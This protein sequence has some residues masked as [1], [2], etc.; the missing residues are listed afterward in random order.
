MTILLDCD[1]V[2]FDFVGA[3]RIWARTQGHTDERQAWGDVPEPTRKGGEGLFDGPRAQL[4]ARV[5]K[6]SRFPQMVLPYPGAARFVEML[7][8]LLY[9]HEKIIAV[10]APFPSPSWHAVRE[11]A[12]KALGIDSVIFCEAKEKK[13]IVGNWLIE[14]TRSTCLDW[15]F[16]HEDDGG[17]A[18]YLDRGTD[19]QDPAD[20]TACTSL[21][22]HK[23]LIT[24]KW[25]MGGPCSEIYP[26][27][28]GTMHGAAPRGR[29]LEGLR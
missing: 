8:G 24:I 10:T 28:V 5:G 3:V 13:R 29:E 21:T 18:I 4:L 11:D 20:E 12:C 27:V 9:S 17:R 22:Q 6:C 2:I 14:D 16:Q 7:R 25:P 26:A 1:G 19:K 23:R 15:L